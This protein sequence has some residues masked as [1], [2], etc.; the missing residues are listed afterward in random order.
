MTTTSTNTV[1]N[2]DDETLLVTPSFLSSIQ[3]LFPS[4][5]TE[6]N[7][8]HIIAAVAYC[9]SNR[10]EAVPEVLKYALEGV[11]RSGG[12]HDERLRVVREIKDGMF[13][14]GMICGYSRVSLKLNMYCI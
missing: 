2:V 5:S 10:P 8:W 6:R 11:D 9:A 4:P 7:P 13:K 12:G 14:A 1:D 3:A